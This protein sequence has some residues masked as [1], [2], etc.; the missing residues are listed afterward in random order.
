MSPI[1]RLAAVAV[2]CCAALTADAVANAG[3]VIDSVESTASGRVPS[4]T[5]G[6]RVSAY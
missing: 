3:V 5:P 6:D 2:V 1:H 4:L